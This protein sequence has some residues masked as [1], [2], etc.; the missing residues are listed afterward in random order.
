MGSSLPIKLI[1]M[2]ANNI[3]IAPIVRYVEY[4][5]TLFDAAVFGG[6]RQYGLPICIHLNHRECRKRSAA[7]A[8]ERQNS[9]AI[10]H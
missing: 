7:H 5:P 4:P 6:L 10:L 8:S 2:Y 3:K 9:T 1:G